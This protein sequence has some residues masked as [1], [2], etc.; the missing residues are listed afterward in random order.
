VLTLTVRW[1]KLS[2]ISQS[3]KAVQ[4]FDKTLACGI[5]EANSSLN[6]FGVWADLQGD[7]NVL[8]GGL[9]KEPVGI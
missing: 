3:F 5:L 8:F 1:G 6:Y 2:F 4:G 9:A 7:F